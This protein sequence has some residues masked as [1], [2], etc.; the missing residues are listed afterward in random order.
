M[1][2]GTLGMSSSALTALGGG[3]PGHVV[4]ATWPSLWGWCASVRVS[5]VPRPPS[6]ALDHFPVSSFLPS[7]N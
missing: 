5:P 3:C 1:G 6:L 7:Q 4:I 2:F